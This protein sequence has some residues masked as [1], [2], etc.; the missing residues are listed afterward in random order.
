MSTE[1]IFNNIVIDNPIA[2]ERFIT[3]LEKAASTTSLSP[4]STIVAEDIDKKDL[5][6]YWEMIKK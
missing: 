3:A 4:T 6:K 1:S 5:N 2:A